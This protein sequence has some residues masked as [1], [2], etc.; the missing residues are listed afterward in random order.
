MLAMKIARLNNRRNGTNDPEIDRQIEIY[1]DELIKK[2]G[3]ILQIEAK[4][5]N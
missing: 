5:G 4:Y 1:Q 3:K 2:Q